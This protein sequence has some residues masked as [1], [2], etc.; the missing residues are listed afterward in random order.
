MFWVDSVGVIMLIIELVVTPFVLAWN[1]PIE[2][3]LQVIMWVNWVYWLLDL[4]LNFNKG[5]YRA[6]VL[7]MQ[8]RA[9]TINY[10]KHWFLPDFL[11][12][13]TDLLALMFNDEVGNSVA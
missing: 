13:L 12:V 8:R 11:L 7:H 9:I 3:G 5:F 10:F 4:I 2:G 1:L 6:G